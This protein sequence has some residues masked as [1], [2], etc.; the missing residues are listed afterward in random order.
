MTTVLV[1]SNGHGEDVIGAMIAREVRALRPSLDVVGF[2]L[3][4]LGKPYRDAHIRIA[5]IQRAMPSGG[6]A[7]HGVR[8]LLRD[9]RAG[10]I[11][12]TA[13][14]IRH[15]RACARGA[16]LAVCVGDAYPLLLAGLFVR[17]PILCLSTAKSEYIHGHYAVE[18]WLM[19]RLAGMVLAR[20]ARTAKALAAVGVRADYA[21]NVMMDGFSI[22]GENFG[23]T[24][25][26]KVVGILP[27]SR[28]EAYRNMVEILG[29]VRRLAEATGN[30]LDFVAG[31]A[32]S[33]DCTLLGQ[34][35]RAAGWRFV[36]GGS[37]DGEAG[38][39]EAGIVGR[40]FPV[41][42][43]EPC[44]ILTQG[45]FGDV[46]NVSNI[47][48]GLSGTG[49]EQAAG[50][51]RPVVAFPTDGPQFNERF[52][53]AQK[54]LLGDALVLVEEGGP[55]AVAREVLSILGDSARVSRMRRAGYERMGE[56]GAATRTA[57]IIVHYLDTGRWEG[58]G[59]EKG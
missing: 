37:K 23:L 21:G 19:R 45:R 47:I 13:N 5:G 51:G 24:L 33:L 29:V 27:G 41:E 35:V 56:Q 9:I 8:L 15:L 11:G 4:G 46:L 50:L 49:N 20:D 30:G 26:K 18:T 6:F 57:K 28:Q 31:L 36:P 42:S 58:C 43:D 52:A 3:V 40:L 44:V 38:D 59:F 14:Q 25:E 1:L 34:A 48:I 39:V 7:K 54:R 53:R 17:R 55:E 22:T 12:H 16:S 32:P 2:P 10:L